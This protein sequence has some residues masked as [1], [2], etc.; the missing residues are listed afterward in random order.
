MRIIIFILL[1]LLTTSIFCFAQKNY[2]FESITVNDGLS[3]SSITSMVQDKFGFLWIATQDGLNKYDGHTFKVYRKKDGDPT[4][5]PNNFVTHV[6]IDPDENLWI[7]TYAGIC[8]YDPV[9]DGFIN[10]SFDDI[11][12]KNNAHTEIFQCRDHSLAISTTGGLIFFNP[13][14]GKFFFREEFKSMKG[15][16]AYYETKT[17]GDWIFAET[18]LHKPAGQN[19]WNTV[20]VNG[21]PF[22]NDDT[23][24]LFL[25]DRKRL[26]KYEASSDSWEEFSKLSGNVHSISTG[27]LWVSGVDGIY[28]FDSSGKFKQHISIY[29]ITSAIISLQI[30]VIFE[31]RDGV[32]WIGTNGYGL[33]KYNPQT[34]RFGY[35][36]S[37][38]N[39]ALQLSHSYVDAIYTSDD[40]TVYVSTP[41]GLDVLNIYKNNSQHVDIP[42]RIFGMTQDHQ[43]TMWFSSWGGLYYFK[44]NQYINSYHYKNTVHKTDLLQDGQLLITGRWEI[45][46]KKGNQITTILS[47]PQWLISKSLLVGDTLWV[48]MAPGGSWKGRCP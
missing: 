42:F 10:Q 2:R 45:I 3:Q 29:E 37:S 4:S 48:G 24:E 1:F 40:S 39:A 21:I 15:V 18:T 23:G 7:V 14:T 6:F 35:V 31:T 38:T 9:T 34:S 36:G 20:E 46:K 41:A 16:L 32:V 27:E 12:P 47:E 13:Q 28:I 8:K 33:K 26:L 25:N 30:S 19:K 11:F 5:L 43:G 17:M 44:N 22:Y